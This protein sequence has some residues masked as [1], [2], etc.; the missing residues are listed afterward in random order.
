MAISFVAL[1]CWPRSLHVLSPLL[2][3]R[4]SSA[5]PC[6]ALLCPAV[7]C[8]AL[9]C[10]ALPCYDTFSILEIAPARWT[11]TRISASAVQAQPCPPSRW[12]T[13]RWTL[14]HEG[15]T[16][17][18]SI[19]VVGET[20]SFSTSFHVSASPTGCRAVGHECRGHYEG[21]CVCVCV[22]VRVMTACVL[23]VT[24]GQ[25]WRRVACR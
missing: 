24:R 5:V 3:L 20:E 10:P 14:A 18:D 23:I 11:E 6:C 1:P 12:M 15:H 21:V 7:P 9:L 13:R 25:A 8:C 2:L 17:I 16:L 19:D 4:C 22:Y